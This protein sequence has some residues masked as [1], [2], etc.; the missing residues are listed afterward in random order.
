M[1]KISRIMAFVLVAMLLCA[2][3]AGC[4][5]AVKDPILESGKQQISLAFYEFM[6]SRMKGE[7][8]R[9]KHDVSAQSDFWGQTA[10]STEQTRE[11]YY[12][13]LVLDRCKNYLAAAI[14]FDEE[15]LNLSDAE[16]A[17][18]DEEIAFYVEY[19]GKNSEEKLD[20]ILSKYGADTDEL[21][22]IY[23]IEA[24][25]RKLMTRLYGAD[26]SQVADTVKQEYYEQNYYRFKQIL[27]SNFYYEY[28]KDELGNVIYFDPETSKPIY[29]TKN[30]KVHYDEDGERVVDAFGVVIYFDEQ[31]NALYDT[32]KGYPTPTLDNNGEA[33]VYKYT[34][35]EMA[36][37]YASAV[38][39]MSSLKKGNYAA[40]EAEMPKWA[41]YSGANDYYPDGYYLSRVESDGYGQYMLDILSSLEKMSNGDIECIESEHGYHIVMKYELDD[42]KFGDSA[43]AEWFASFNTSIQ[44]KLFLDRCGKIYQNITV[45]EENIKKARSI[46]EIGTN[47]NY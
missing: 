4:A 13:A 42:G 30:G 26:G 19:D 34:D 41:I 7:L 2:T 3:F 27:I 25:Y 6:L 8:A 11:Q 22:E 29:D 14:L 36:E 35:A 44:N 1:K 16:L 45:N 39:L 10:S 46:V 5:K 20:A 24:K 43:Y 32:E 37:R 23:I 21:R 15:G 18:I 28:Q 38:S 31:G 33:I 47:Y 40:F 9:D 17:E 12:N